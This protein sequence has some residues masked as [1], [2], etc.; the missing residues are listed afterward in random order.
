MT[1]TNVNQL[2]DINRLLVSGLLWSVI[3]CFVLHDCIFLFIVSIS[4]FY[5]CIL[6][7][8]VTKVTPNEI[9]EMTVEYGNAVKP[10]CLILS[11]ST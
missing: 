8:K 2:L 1:K 5:F 11:G 7:T 6:R 4:Y 9:T 10:H 3:C